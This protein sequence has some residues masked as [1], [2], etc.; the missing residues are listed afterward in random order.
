MALNPFALDFWGA[1]AAEIVAPMAGDSEVRT[2][3]LNATRAISINAA[4]EFV[5]PWLRQMGFGRAGWYSYDW[6]DNL[7]KPSAT[8]IV[9]EWQNVAV[10]DPIPAGPFAFTAT[11]V[12]PDHAFCI[13]QTSRFNVFSL[14][15]ELRQ[16]GNGTRLVSRA[17]ARFDIPLGSPFVSAVLGP[18]DGIMVRKQLLGIRT[19]AEALAH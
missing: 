13:T 4:P 17:R 15:F 19:R 11:V 10:G 5:F 12:E 2:P 1:T 9:P 7:G 8:T 18:G 16:Q 14:A 3:M 6:I